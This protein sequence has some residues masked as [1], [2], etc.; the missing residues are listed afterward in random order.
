MTPT[1][2]PSLR[3]AGSQAPPPPFDAELAGP[4]RRILGGLPMPLT[5]ELIPDRRRRSASG[6]LGDEEI[7]RGGT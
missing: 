3:Q 7:R 2:S 1:S 6:R 4:I 5:S